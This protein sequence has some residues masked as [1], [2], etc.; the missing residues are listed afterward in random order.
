EYKDKVPVNT[1]ATD[2]GGSATNTAVG[3][4]R[5]GLKVG[6]SA[7]HG[8][9]AMGMF[10]RKKLRDEHVD[11]RR[12]EEEKGGQTNTSVI[13]VHESERTILPYYVPRTYKLS[14]L[15][16]ARW[17]YLTTGGKGFEATYAS[18]LHQADAN[19]SNLVVNAGPYQLRHGRAKVLSL[20]RESHLFISNKEEMQMAVGRRIED[21]ADLLRE[22][23][24]LTPGLILMT[25]G[26]RGAF[27][28]DGE[29]I[30][31][32]DPFPHKT[33]EKTGAGDAFTAGFL[34]AMISG[35]SV[36]DALR[37]GSIN[38]AS[39]IQ[40]V[41]AQTGLLTKKELSLTLE[42]HKTFK[43]HQL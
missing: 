17:M 23:R 43:P 2:V 34:T 24:E 37:A 4:S 13:L 29:K 28:F 26:E 14:E 30:M 38:A 36:S 18:I 16:K 7:V 9:D 40:H 10:V 39:V 5:L 6:L 35:G 1:F 31:H 12:I 8:D 32:I 20:I 25:D 3:V 22:V 33:V 11:D 27:S 41:G 15:P 42:K 19:K 21:D